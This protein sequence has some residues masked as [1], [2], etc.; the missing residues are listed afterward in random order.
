MKVEFFCPYWGSE[1]LDHISFFE[2]IKDAGYDGAEIILPYDDQV[3][4]RITEIAK[5]LDLKII[6]L[7]GGVIDGNFEQS[8]K[9]YEEHLRNACSINPL[10]VNIQTGKDHYTFEQNV[11]FLH[12]ANKIGE[13]IGVKILHETH[14]GKF[15]YAAHLMPKY[16][17]E[18][19]ELRI[20][21]DFS[22]WCSVAESLL[23]DQEEHISL[24]IERSDHIHARVG[25]SE[26]P[27]IP[28]P[29]TPEWQTTVETHIAWWD[30]IIERRK[31]EGSS[32]TTIT[33]EFGP[34]PYM[35]KMPYTGM[36]IT[37]QWD[38]NLYMKN[39]LNERYN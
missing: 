33:P 23:E 22:H 4:H 1:H 38:V 36:P 14:R 7:W 32:V 17:K 5:K 3:K 10:F 34:F 2:K 20:T 28:D 31:S 19:S 6:A 35:T 29:R 8:I 30:K 26:G 39:I 37:S 9:T 12:L 15:S 11:K 13:E 18:F 21:A 27:Q 25:F 16:F 24:A